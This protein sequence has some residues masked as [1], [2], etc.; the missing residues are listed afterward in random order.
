MERISFQDIIPGEEGHS[1]AVD[2][3]VD[4]V[5]ADNRMQV[6]VLSRSPDKN[7]SNFSNVAPPVVRV[8]SSVIMR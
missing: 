7:S 6:R 5:V 8:K 3:P 4:G 1:G 2:E